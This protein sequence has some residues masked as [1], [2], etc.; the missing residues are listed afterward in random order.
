[1]WGASLFAQVNNE[2]QIANRLMQ[3]QRYVD[4][5]P[6][7]EKINRQQPD[8]FIFFDRLIE[9]YIQLKEYDTAQSNIESNISNNRNPALSNVLLGEVLHF[10]GDTTEAYTVWRNN[11]ERYSNQL[12]LYINTANTMLDRREY[13]R[14]IEVYRKGREVFNNS[15]LF[16]T[17]IPN[18]YMQAGNYDAAIEEWLNLIQ[19]DPRQISA[20][21]RML[22]RYDDPFLY[23]IAILEL[24]DI[25]TEM[26]LNDPAYQSFYELEIWL[27]LENELYRRA[28]TTAREYES[29]TSSYNFSLFNVG[30]KLSDNN[31]FELA[32]DAFNYYTENSF[33]EV[34]WRATE[35]KASVYTRWAKYLDDYSLDFTGKRDSLFNQAK[36]LL[37]TLTD[38]TSNY[39]RIEQVYLKKAELSLDFVFDLAAAKEATRRLKMYRNMNES[40]ESDYLDGR[41]A[42]A[43]QEFTNARISLTRSNKKAEV[44]ELAEKTRY[45]LALTDFYAGDFEFAK[46]QL[47]TLGRQNTSYYANDA[48]ELRLWLQEGLS[49]DTTGALLT[50]FASAHF[51]LETGQKEEA[52]QQFLA[53]ANSEDST[54]FKDDAYILLSKVSKDHTLEYYQNISNY[55]ESSPYISQKEKMMWQI[56]KLADELYSRIDPESQ[57]SEDD[58]LLSN[59]TV[60][61]SLDTVIRAYENIL[62]EFPQGFYAPYARKR[63]NELPKANS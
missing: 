23:D 62:L 39:S 57:E 51:N 38:E 42:L 49:A 4:A 40:P 8:V 36:S 25:L 17:D 60:E 13:S 15:K 22:L 16:L 56:A 63:L 14:A 12:Q 45:F 54:P 41:I 47:K 20:I 29:K 11:L 26:P 43:E 21:Q 33:G 2:F 7:L 52:R 6:I 24:E 50:D 53:I 35:E 30:R 58:P 27:L 37:D 5:L 31:E 32:I 48:L 10:K 18:A 46:I 34:K 1:L 44:G 3:Q 19:E 9:C 28:F 59:A 61:R 55:V